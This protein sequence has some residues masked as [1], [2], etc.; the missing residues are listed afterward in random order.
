MEN[1][2]LRLIRFT[3]AAGHIAG[4]AVLL[5]GREPLFLLPLLSWSFLFFLSSDNQ[6]REAN[7]V[8]LGDL[9][10][11]GSLLVASLFF[12]SLLEAANLVLLHRYYL[13]MPAEIWLRWPLHICSFA[14]MIPLI[15]EIERKLENLGLAEV[16]IWRK[17]VMSR[18]TQFV[19]MAA[20][21][22]LLIPL[23]IS[24]FFFYP[25][26]WIVLLLLTDPL[27]QLVGQDQ[28]SISGQ[29]EE[30]YYGQAFRLIL[31]GVLFGFFW[32]F[33]NFQAGAK[34]FYTSSGFNQVHLFELPLL[35]F[36]GY[37]F[38]ALAAYAFYQL[39]LVLNE[40]LLQVMNR[41]AVLITEILALALVLAAIL[42]GMDALT[43]VSFRQVI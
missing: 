34:W 16:L 42:A 35:E 43:T 2:I 8:L 18:G 15:L 22:L 41:K 33:W 10:R 31:A 21:L 29:F 40:K 19:F 3:A 30:G 1:K 4:L 26:L 14:A 5:M 28:R 12:G 6:I 27:L 36:W 39:F 17:I 7:S 11:A 9:K 38:T 25:L 13:G 20:G 24:P 32:E 23:V 37:A